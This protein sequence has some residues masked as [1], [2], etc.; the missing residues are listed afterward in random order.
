M[1]I[2]IINSISTNR[3]II[4]E[5]NFYLRTEFASYAI[6]ISIV[7][8]D[9]LK[10]SQMLNQTWNR[11]RCKLNNSFVCICIG[12]RR[13]WVETIIRLGSYYGRNRKLQ[14]TMICISGNNQTIKVEFNVVKHKTPKMSIKKTVCV[15]MSLFISSL[16]HWSCQRSKSLEMLSLH[17]F[18]ANVCRYCVVRM[19]QQ[20]HTHPLIQY[21]I[22]FF[23]ILFGMPNSIETIVMKS[24]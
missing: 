24:I 16:V 19:Q 22:M 4:N 14:K 2:N 12:D 20:Q 10:V 11:L 8:T 7:V 17:Q 23:I 3:F 13:G 21:L 15:Q 1:H 5:V 18:F 9:K 6:D